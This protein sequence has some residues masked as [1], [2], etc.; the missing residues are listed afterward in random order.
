MRVKPIVFATLNSEAYGYQVDSQRE[1]RTMWVP[2]L[3]SARLGRAPIRV[4]YWGTPVVVF[5]TASGRVGALEDV[6]P[7]RGVALSRGEVDGEAIRCGFHHFRFATDGAC[8]SVP[9]RF[10]A[11]LPLDACQARR[12]FVREA[13]G[14]VWVSVED[15]AEAPFPIDETEWPDACLLT[16]GSFDVAGDLRVWMDH[17]LDAPHLV[18]THT[19]SVYAAEAGRRAEFTSIRIDID[20]TSR[21][22][23]RHALEFVLG[24][25]ARGGGPAALR[26]LRKLLAAGLPKRALTRPRGDGE[27]RVRVRADL[28]TPLCQETWTRL[29]GMN[30]RI[31]TSVTPVA[32][33][34]NR[35]LYAAMASDGGIGTLKRWL[36]G[37]LVARGIERHLR[38]EDS[39]FLPSARFVEA[40]RFF[41]TP[42]DS[43]V[44]SMRA[45][46]AAYQR[47]RAHR[48]PPDSLMR[49]LRYGVAPRQVVP[50]VPVPQD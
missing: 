21:Y 31:W 46:F 29:G 41:E 35:F 36:G 26:P 15:D 6:C 2:L 1:D 13:V 5:R 44:Q 42:L 14:L 17:F 49:T 38:V 4:S 24:V 40:Q 9:D 37:R 33:N 45:V 27:Y 39:R 10:G 47:E 18:P 12:F 8:A 28:I 19:R 11:G 50:I 23:V 7:H 43:T 48:Y 3:E 34:R 20:P 30:L 22:P 25:S 32:E 16:T